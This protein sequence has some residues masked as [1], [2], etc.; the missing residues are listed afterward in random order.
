M[1]QAIVITSISSPNKAMRSFA[2]GTVKNNMDFWVIG[3]VSSPTHFDLP[4]CRF[5]SLEDQLQTEFEY[6][7]SCPTRHYSRKNIGYL[8]AIKSGAELIT[9]T[10]DDNLPFDS[11]WEARK[12]FIKAPYVSDSGWCNVYRYFSNR[13]IWPR[14]LPLEFI[15]QAPT[16]LK[17]LPESEMFCPIH[18]GLAN[19]NPDVDAIFRLAFDLPFDFQNPDLQIIIGGSAWCPFNSQNTRWFKEAF[20]LL[21]LPSY[22]SFRMTDIWRSFVAKRICA[23]NNW[24]IVFHGATVWQE[25]NE[26]NLMRDFEDELPGYLNNSKIAITL[27]NLKLCSGISNI[28]SNLLECYSALAY[29]NLIPSKEIELLKL[30][31]NDIKLLSN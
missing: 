31:L 8:L 6:A 22:C 10:D 5:I 20:P 18:Q 2:E 9:D 11:F 21:Y 28:S 23:E 1:K 19:S 16:D 13:M 30:W 24:G 27:N 14:G 3:D 4:G 25:R 17:I 7:R 12:P 15:K 29:E 26:H